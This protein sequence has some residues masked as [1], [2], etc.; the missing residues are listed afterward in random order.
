MASQALKE[1]N[2][3]IKIEMK[4]SKYFLGINKIELGDP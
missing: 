4:K 3:T 2:L 1:I